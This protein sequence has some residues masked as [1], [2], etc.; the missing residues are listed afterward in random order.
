MICLRCNIGVL[1]LRYF[2]A[3]LQEFDL[4]RFLSTESEQLTWKA[5]GLPSDNLSM[6][7]A[8]VILQVRLQLGKLCVPFSQSFCHV[9]IPKTSNY[10]IVVL[11]CMCVYEHL[12]VVHV[13]NFT[14]RSVTF[15]FGVH[16]GHESICI[17]HGIE[18]FILLHETNN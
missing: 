9:T 5:E 14:F 17:S 3:L 7:N 15:V 10:N 12:V 4:R 1:R 16:S 2:L 13:F 6:E 11:T 8:V 18:L